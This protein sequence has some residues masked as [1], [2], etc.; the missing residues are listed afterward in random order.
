MI[1][2]ND[3]DEFHSS[4]QMIIRNALGGYPLNW[5]AVDDFGLNT[6]EHMLNIRTALRHDVVDLHE[7]DH[8]LDRARCNGPR[9]TELIR[10]ALQDSTILPYVTAQDYQL[11]RGPTLPEIM[12]SQNESQT[13]KID[14]A[15]C[16]SRDEQLER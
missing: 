4:T 16:R 8:E 3:L 1:R 2:L 12:K 11:G 9:I 14:Q 15:K 6:R 10:N 13:K 5:E 7:L